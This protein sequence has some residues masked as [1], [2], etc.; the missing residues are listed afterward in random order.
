M[1]KVFWKIFFCSNKHKFHRLYNLK[2]DISKPYVYLLCGNTCLFVGGIL[3][4]TPI[5]PMAII[6]VVL[7]FCRYAIRILIWSRFMQKKKKKMCFYIKHKIQVPVQPNP[8]NFW[9]NRC[10]WHENELVRRKMQCKHTNSTLA[11]LR[12]SLLYAI[13]AMTNMS[14]K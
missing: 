4:T 6:A 1:R 7:I 3:F 12:S 9:K 8:C 5:T 2:N 11:V 10:H 14:S 13:I